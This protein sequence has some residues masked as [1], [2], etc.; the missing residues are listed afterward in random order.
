[1]DERAIESALAACEQTLAAGGAPDLRASG[2]WRAV[3]AAK[4]RPE[5]VARYGERIAR[6]DHATF[7]RRVR[8]VFPAPVGVV[9]VTG[10]LVVALALLLGAAQ[11]APPARE[12]LLLAGALGLD[13]AT[14]G[15]AHL[16]VGA[17]VGIR[18]TDWFIDLPRRP[19]PGFKID[20]ASYLGTPPRAR[21]WMHASGAIATKLTPF[22][23]LAYGLAIGADGWALAVLLVV[24]ALQIL[25]DVLL[26]VKSS[27][28]KKFRR[29]MKLA[30]SS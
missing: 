2:F 22:L 15:L 8:L 7:R 18:F 26:S 14:H 9:L 11:V 23:V 6:V 13:I 1:M 24:G 3:A 30:R 29:E 21:A 28:W 27:D 4:R 16:V 5:L 25:S 19:Q 20:Y 12:I 10:G 17:A